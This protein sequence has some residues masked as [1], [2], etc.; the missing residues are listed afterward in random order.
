ME[1]W[2]AYIQLMRIYGIFIA[3][4]P[5]LGA[6]SNGIFHGFVFLIIVGICS[7]IFGFVQNDYFDIEIDRK[8]GHVSNRP[9]ASGLISKNEAII[10]MAILLIIAFAITIFLFSAYA[11]L[12]L[13]LYFFFYT[14]YNRYSKK[15]AFME[16]SLGLA[17]TMIF[18][19]G[20]FSFKEEISIYCFLISLLPILKY[21]FNVGISAN[22]K[23]IEYDLKQGVRT[24][25]SLFGMN[26]G[27]LLIP[28][29]FVLYS[30]SLKIIYVIVAFF[31]L[32]TMQMDAYF[33]L[34]LI[35]TSSL[36]LFY[37]IKKIFDNF[38]NRREML[39]YA[40]IHEIL[41]YVLMAS[42]LYDYVA[43]NYNPFLSFSLII[44]P[45]LWILLSLKILFGGK[46]LE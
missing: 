1:K 26:L 35:I 23:D 14:V 39:F 8:S 46:P 12:F 34:L 4:M 37:T 38:G 16:Y 43:V 11:L 25:P 45:P 18:L 30:Y 21:A 2:K 17:G 20:A 7:N 28:K 10:F 6:I 33:S 5:L 40:E 15:F 24:T 32:Y 22:L 41:A 44:L 31:A 19:Y 27:K 9:L 29:S 36:F 42:I 3:M 13:V